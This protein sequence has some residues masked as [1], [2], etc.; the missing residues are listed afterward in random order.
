MALNLGTCP[1]GWFY[2]FNVL[3]GM[4]REQRIRALEQQCERCLDI[5][6]GVFEEVVI[7]PV[8]VVVD[9]GVFRS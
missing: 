1:T 3:N 5:C 8:P 4:G 7:M 2:S 9:P 6:C